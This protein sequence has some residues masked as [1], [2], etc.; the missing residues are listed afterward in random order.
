MLKVGD[1]CVAVHKCSFSIFMHVWKFTRSVCQCPQE[2]YRFPISWNTCRTR[3]VNIS[4]T[5]PK[6]KDIPAS[7]RDMVLISSCSQCSRALS[8]GGRERPPAKCKDGAWT[9]G[10]P[11]T[12]SE[13][14]HSVMFSHPTNCVKIF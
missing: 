2:F 6:H 5:A 3:S 14:E 12:E 4:H 11:G 13:P 7:S 1:E 9:S 10:S 8:Q